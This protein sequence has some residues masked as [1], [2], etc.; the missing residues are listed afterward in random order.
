MCASL[1]FF[2]GHEQK[3][4]LKSRREKNTRMA[5]KAAVADVKF[6]LLCRR[7]NEVFYFSEQFSAARA[8]C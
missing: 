2:T 6:G 1:P 4:N 8:F 3:E 7:A 5:S